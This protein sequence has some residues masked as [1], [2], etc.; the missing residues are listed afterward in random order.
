MKY[1][2][3]ISIVLL[4]L[5]VVLAG[6]SAQANSQK[7]VMME[8]KPASGAMM[9]KTSAPVME[10]SEEAMMDKTAEPMENKPT[11]EMS[12]DKMMSDL[13]AWY[14]A[15]LVNVNTGESFT[16]E[17]L[18][19]KVILVETLA[20][21]CSNCLKQQNQ[22][23]ALHEILGDR[24]DFVSIG[25]DIDPNEDADALKEYTTRNGFDW[26]YAVSTEDV[27]RELSQ[28]YGA[29][30]LN[31]PSTPMLIIDRK[32]EAHPLPFGI[33]SADE[34]LKALQPFLDENM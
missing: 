20:Q 11:S 18:N 30:F 26:I 9:E 15:E 25:L 3:K 27:S 31:P 5:A 13:P 6:C 24:E 17:A 32:G 28:L 22:V 7:N 29:Q 12:E 23:K 10:K 19:G 34:L 21:W 14:K 2:R 8:E 16:I 1:S 33:K 4:M